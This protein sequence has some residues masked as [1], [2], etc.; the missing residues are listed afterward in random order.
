MEVEVR[1]GRE[2][3]LTAEAAHMDMVC[4]TWQQARGMG[5]GVHAGKKL[6]GDGGD[7]HNHHHNQYSCSPLPHLP[8]TMSGYFQ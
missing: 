6:F 2:R 8:A 3:Q 7:L 4:H 5:G 1:P